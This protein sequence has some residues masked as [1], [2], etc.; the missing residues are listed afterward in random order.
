[1]L[2]SEIVACP[3]CE[4]E[5]S[6]KVQR[7]SRLAKDTK[8]FVLADCPNCK[9]PSNKLEKM[10]NGRSKIKTERSYIKLDPRARG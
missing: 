3:I 10:L 7:A 8:Y 9:T 2:E 1:M 5:I 6:V 4:K